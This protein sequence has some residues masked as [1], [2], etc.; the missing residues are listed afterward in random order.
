MCANEADDELALLAIQTHAIQGH[1]CFDR[2]IS[3]SQVVAAAEAV[4]PL[5]PEHEPLLPEHEEV[6][7]ALLPEHEFIELD[8]RRVAQAAASDNADNSVQQPFESLVCMVC[9]PHLIFV[10]SCAGTSHFVA[11]R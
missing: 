11:F 3:A 10:S 1:S 5:L 7:E 6:A 2:S 8:E 9:F 4:S